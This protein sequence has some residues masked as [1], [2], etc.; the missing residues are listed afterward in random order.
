MQTSMEFV[1]PS[2][3]NNLITQRQ[4]WLCTQEDI[5]FEIENA[6]PSF[7]LPSRKS[8]VERFLLTY[9]ETRRREGWGNTDVEY[10][11]AL[12][13]HDQSGN[14]KRLWRT[15][16]RTFDCFIEH[17]QTRRVNSHRR[18]LDIGAGDG[19]ISFQLAK[20]GFEMIA[21]DINMDP[22]DGLGVLSRMQA[23]DRANITPVR[24]E[25]DYLPFP[26]SSVDIIVFNASLHY[27]RDILQTLRKSM[28]LLREH[29]VL[30]TLDS[31][32]YRNAESGKM[33][34]QERREKLQEQYSITIGDEFAGNFL[35][36][37]L[38][39][40][41]QPNYHIE[42]LTPHY[43]FTWKVRPLIA[44]ILKRREPATFKVIAISVDG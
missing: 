29:G 8:A 31:P 1:C 27:S 26:P 7:I 15:R 23:S 4:G 9:Q 33:M 24:A 39:D 36:F 28:V 34:I 18:I 38:L 2:C 44:A 12:P 30:Y 25:F 14:H 40:Q 11:C 20:R 35:T 10:Y 41:I 16:S 19:W 22:L 3:K 32:I 5:L 43:G 42:Y 13:Y 17:L 6:I 37:G 21:L